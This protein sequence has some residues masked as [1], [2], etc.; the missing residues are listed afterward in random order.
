MATEDIRVCIDKTLPLQEAMDAADR[1]VEE[2]PANAPLIQPRAALGIEPFARPRIALITAKRWNNGRTLRVRFTGGDPAVQLKVQQYAHQWSQHAN[3]TFAFGTDPD[4]EIRIAFQSGAGSWSYIGTDA[5][6][7]PK[8][9][10]T[11]N[12]GWLTPNT[13]DDEY[14]RVVIHE[15]GHAL[16]CIHEHQ[17]PVAGIPWNREAVYRYYMQS[18]GWS[19]ADV[20]VNLFQK[21]DRASTQFSEFDPKSIMLYAI[22]KELTV[23]GFE[24]G[25]N[26]V[27]SPTDIAFGWNRV[28]SPTDIAFIATQYPMVSKPVV[29]LKL[30]ARSTQASLGA[31]GEED[32][33]R[34]IV[35]T[36]GRYVLKTTGTTDVKMG[37]YGPDNQT[38]QIAEDDDS[39]WLTNAKIDTTLNPGTYYLKVKHFHPTG[40]GSYRV[41]AAAHRPSIF[42][43]PKP[44]RRTSGTG[45]SSPTRRGSAPR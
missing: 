29:D 19:R 43:T 36:A 9:Q 17:S 34:F 45:T 25:W 31:P 16:G 42:G 11:M 23:G 20:D 18:Q 28:L 6:S 10:P 39:G 7:I 41:A 13:A 40:T 5:L 12:Y 15:F 30:G 33:Y 27:L 21:Y 44:R 3:I 32:L 14:S 22:P 1:A 2:N 8:S 24:A 4:A 35:D 37:L 26:R 38:V